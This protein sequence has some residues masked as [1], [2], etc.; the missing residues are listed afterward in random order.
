MDR[1]NFL[2]A[3]MQLLPS[4]LEKGAVGGRGERWGGGAHSTQRLLAH[5]LCLCCLSP[6]LIGRMFLREPS[7]KYSAK[8]VGS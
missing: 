6:F 7:W 4:H 5:C 1:L 2:N 8:L 3:V